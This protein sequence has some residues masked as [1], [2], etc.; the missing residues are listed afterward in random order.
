[1]QPAIFAKGIGKAY[2]ERLFGPRKEVLREV[3]LEVVPGAIFGVLGPNGAGKTTLIS[4]LATLLHPDAGEA[5]VLGL[6]VVKEAGRLRQR[7]NLAAAGAH[8]LCA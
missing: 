4:I 8:F 3:D 2:R 7:I 6:D 5:R 1:M